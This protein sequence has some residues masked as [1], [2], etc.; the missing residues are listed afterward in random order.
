M[1]TKIY[2]VDD[3]QLAILKTFPP[4]LRIVATGMVNTGGWSDPQLV[5]YIYVSPPADGIYDFDF[6]ASPPS[7]I[8]IQVIL[9]ITATYHWRGFPQE[10][11]G[12]RIH[13]CSGSLED[14]L[15]TTREINFKV[16]QPEG[17]MRVPLFIT[18]IVVEEGIGF[19]RDGATH[20]L[21]YN[22]DCGFQASMRLKAN[23]DEVGAELRR[24]SGTRQSVMVAGYLKKGIEPECDY[25]NTYHVGPEIKPESF[26]SLALR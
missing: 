1:H 21:L 2:S 20:R 15:D 16:A 23:N 6:I 5:P 25:L 24:V 26:A 4:T 14:M 12:V 10:L 11:K 3:V 13:A 17:D 8:A 22:S 18:G 7:G 19:C 9:P